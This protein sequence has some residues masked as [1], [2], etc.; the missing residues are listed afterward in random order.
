MFPKA[1]RKMIFIQNDNFFPAA[2]FHD[3]VIYPSL[4][5]LSPPGPRHNPPLCA[6]PFEFHPLIVGLRVLPE[7]G[8][9]DRRREGA[10]EGVGVPP[11]LGKNAPDLSRGHSQ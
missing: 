10:A 8:V 3:T 2:H 11:V 5:L 4:P 1:V 6:N 9:G 7:N